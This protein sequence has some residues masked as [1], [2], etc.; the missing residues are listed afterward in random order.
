MSHSS[1]PAKTRGGGRSAG[2]PRGAP[3]STQRAIN[4]ISSA[5]RETSSLKSWMPTVLSMNQGGIT[6]TGLSRLV[7]CLML[8]AQGR[9]SSYVISDI[10]AMESGR[11]QFWQLRWRIGAMSRA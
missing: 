1:A 10:G 4:P 6:P 7:R 8:R 11:W 2:L 9:T 5:L 3:L